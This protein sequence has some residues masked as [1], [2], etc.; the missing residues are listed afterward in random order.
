MRYYQLSAIF[1]LC[2]ANV[3]LQA[4]TEDGTSGDGDGGSTGD[5]DGDGDVESCEEHAAS[6]CPS[7]GCDIARAVKLTEIDAVWCDPG[8]SV[9]DSEFLVEQCRSTE[10]DNC[11]GGDAGRY[12]IDPQGDHW[13]TTTNCGLVG[14]EPADDEDVP[15]CG[16]I[17][18]GGGGAGGAQN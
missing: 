12:W 5:G 2:L 9:T 4:C 6:D 15:F 10:A 16:D 14:H 13:K 3:L 17:G 7:A 18:M 1:T 11:E 8:G